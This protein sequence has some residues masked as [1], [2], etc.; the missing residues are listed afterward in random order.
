MGGFQREFVR[1]TESIAQLRNCFSSHHSNFLFFSG[2]C[3][4]SCYGRD[5]KC[6]WDNIWSKTSQSVLGN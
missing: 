4:L 2:F 6:W 5:I 1:Q 3:F